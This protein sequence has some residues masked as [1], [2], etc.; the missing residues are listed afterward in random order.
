M[1][2]ISL[3]YISKKLSG[4]RSEEQCSQIPICALVARLIKSSNMISK[5][6]FFSFH[7]CAFISRAM[8]HQSCLHFMCSHS[9]ETQGSSDRLL[10]LP[11]PEFFR[12]FQFFSRE[13][14]C[15]SWNP[16]CGVLF[17]IIHP[18]MP[19]SSKCFLSSLYRI[20]V[21]CFPFPHVRNIPCPCHSLLFYYP[22]NI[23]CRV[24]IMKFLLMSLLTFSSSSLGPNIFFSILFLK[25]LSQCLPVM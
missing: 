6:T 10:V 24:Q 22:S 20:P 19:G 21:C 16:F 8:L 18:F 23:W 17:N 25:T 3:V 5:L 1:Q 2:T 14:T 9:M 4:V 15:I 11:G 7:S 12:S 13:I